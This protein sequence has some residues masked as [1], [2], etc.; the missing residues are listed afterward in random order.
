MK[1]FSIKNISVLVLT[2]IYLTTLPIFFS[3]VSAHIF[4]NNLKSISNL[5]LIGDSAYLI[6][7]LFFAILIFFLSRGRYKEDKRFI[8]AIA[9]TIIIFI[10]LCFTNYG[11][12]TRI[13]SIVMSI[14]TK[15]LDYFGL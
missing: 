6:I 14:F 8:W 2:F 5:T 3:I 10:I 4:R 11:F 7:L 13:G 15:V 1:Y 9:V 12:I